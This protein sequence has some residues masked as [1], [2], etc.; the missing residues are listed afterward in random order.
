MNTMS[1]GG[2]CV[3]A[4]A[5][6]LLSYVVA[7]PVLVVAHRLG[8]RSLMA[9]W[10]VAALVGAPV[11]YLW[12]NPAAFS[13]EPA[14]TNVM[15][16]PN[17]SLL[18]GYMALFGMTG[19]LYAAGAKPST[20]IQ[21]FGSRTILPSTPPRSRRWCALATSPN[22]MRSDM[23]GRIAPQRASVRSSAR[24]ARNHSERL[25]RIVVIE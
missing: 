6:L 14:E 4:L 13:D 22:P 1:I 18:L 17:W 16:S 7:P 12:A 2:P 8:L 10:L 3:W 24:S 25:P 11:G 23:R 20:R 9:L 19:L 15:Q 5:D 21:Q